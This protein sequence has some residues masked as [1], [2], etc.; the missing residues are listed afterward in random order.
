M[1]ESAEMIGRSVM[2]GMQFLSGGH[3]LGTA[4]ES[5]RE[6]AR[7]LAVG[8]D[9]LTGHERVPVPVDVLQQAPAAG[10]EVVLDAGWMEAQ[11]IEVDDVHIGSVT[12]CK[13]APVEEPDGAGR[14][15]ALLLDDERDVELLAARA[16][17]APV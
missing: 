6:R 17:P 1:C 7:G 3:R 10:G 4:H 15:P 9:L 14:L 11:R 5:A 2:V 13:H 16:V 8:V 12:G